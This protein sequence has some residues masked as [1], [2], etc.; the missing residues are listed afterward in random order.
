MF[1]EIA[2]VGGRDIVDAIADEI[3]IATGHVF[4]RT[5]R[6]TLQPIQELH[7]PCSSRSLSTYRVLAVINT[8]P[9]SKAHYIDD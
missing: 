3:L 4:F 9:A 7:D 2:V 8:L 1:G 5:P 6:P